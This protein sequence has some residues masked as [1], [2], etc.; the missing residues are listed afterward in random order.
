MPSTGRRGTNSTCCAA[1]W[2]RALRRR[3]PEPLTRPLFPHHGYG[4]TPLTQTSSL[5]G[6]VIPALFLELT[7]HQEHHLYPSVPSHHLPELARRLEPYFCQ[8]RVRLR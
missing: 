4:A 7:Y 3:N 2:P 6:R 5:R 8:A 1:N